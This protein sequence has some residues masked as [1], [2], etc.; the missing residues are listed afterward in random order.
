LVLQAG[1][2]LLLDIGN[3]SQSLKKLRIAK[4]MQS[5]ENSDSFGLNIGKIEEKWMSQFQQMKS[6]PQEATKLL[7]KFNND[8]REDLLTLLR[9]DL[10]SNVLRQ[11]VVP[12]RILTITDWKSILHPT[13]IIP[14]FHPPEATTVDEGPDLDEQT[15]DAEIMAP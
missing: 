1:I 4:A 7:L 3:A 15:E 9:V 2:S 10:R 14:L 12:R 11:L 8:L 13:K 5:Q 6:M